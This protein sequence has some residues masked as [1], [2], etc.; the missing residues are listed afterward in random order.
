M[1]P[2]IIMLR[3]NYFATTLCLWMHFKYLLN[4][5]ALIYLSLIHLNIYVYYDLQISTFSKNL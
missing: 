4:G 2:L 3:H 1:P 5:K